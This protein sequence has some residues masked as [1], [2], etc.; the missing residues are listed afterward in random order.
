MYTKR[1]SLK[2]GIGGKK[3][4]DMEKVY[5]K[6]D[7]G[8]SVESVAKEY[9]VSKSTLYR[10]HAEYQERMEAITRA[11]FRNLQQ[12]EGLPPLPE[13]IKGHSYLGEK[14]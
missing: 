8:R 13:E 3:L 9:G 14:L 4:I 5:Q 1:K 6:L 10:R 2:N 12:T 11:S 7:T